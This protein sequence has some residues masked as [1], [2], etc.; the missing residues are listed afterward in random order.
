MITQQSMLK[1][2]VAGGLTIALLVGISAAATA[3]EITVTNDRFSEQVPSERVF[4]GDL[5]LASVAGENTLNSRVRGA[6]RRVC[7]AHS[8]DALP[9]M[10]CR[11]FAWRGA[12][13]QIERALTRA[14]DIAA[15]GTSAIPPV[16]ILIATPR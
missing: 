3:Q 9:H 1:A 6:V 12:K 11:S 13:P 5:N 14:R 2:S 10:A 8:G 16:A 4:F 15:R 7:Q